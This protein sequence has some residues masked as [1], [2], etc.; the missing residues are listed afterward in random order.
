MYVCVC[1]GQCFRLCVCVCLCVPCPTLCSPIGCSPPGSSVQRIFQARI[2]EWV[3]ISSSMGSSQHRDQTWVSCIGSRFFYH[4]VAYKAPSV[5]MGEVLIHSSSPFIREDKTDR[6]TRDQ[7]LPNTNL[8]PFANLETLVLDFSSFSPLS[9]F[10]SFY[11]AN[12][13]MT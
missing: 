5:W 8:A 9:F 2:L 13:R 10:L 3:A 7:K 6:E 12:K 11:Y 4:W 1:V